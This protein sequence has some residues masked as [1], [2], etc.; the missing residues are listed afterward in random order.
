VRRWPGPQRQRSPAAG[1]SRR[2]AGGSSLTVRHGNGRTRDQAARL[3][4]CCSSTQPPVWRAMLVACWCARAIVEST[5]T[6]QFSTPTASAC[7]VKPASTSSQVPPAAVRRC[8]IQTRPEH[9]GQITPGDPA[10]IPVDDRLDHRPRIRERPPLTT[11]PR[12]QHRRDQRPLSIREQP[13]PRHTP[14]LAPASRDL[15]QTRA[16]SIPALTFAGVAGGAAA[17]AATE[18]TG[19]WWWLPALLLWAITLSTAAATET[20]TRS[21]YPRR[22]FASAVAPLCCS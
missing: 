12:R 21:G 13:K 19:S 2:P 22:Y 1:H 14:T 9:L 10:P 15:C 8:Q 4:D 5:A 3:A 6:D 20:P 7:A 17:I 18:R 16:T 11:R